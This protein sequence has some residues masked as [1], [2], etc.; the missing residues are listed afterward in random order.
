MANQMRTHG[1][2]STWDAIF[3]YLNLNRHKFDEYGNFDPSPDKRDYVPPALATD[4]DSI[5]PS[6]DRI[7]RRRKTNKPRYGGLYRPGEG[8]EDVARE[9]N[10]NEA[11]EFADGIRYDADKCQSN[12]H[13]EER[14]CGDGGYSSGCWERARERYSNCTRF[15]HYN[16]LPIWT[17][18]D[19][20][21]EADQDLDRRQESKAT[22]DL[23]PKPEASPKPEDE[24]DK[25]ER[26]TTDRA[27]ANLLANPFLRAQLAALLGGPGMLRDGSTDRRPFLRK[28]VVLPSDYPKGMDRP[29]T[30]Y[31]PQPYL[32]PALGG[33]M[34]AQAGAGAMGARLLSLTPR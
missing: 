11:K 28:I 22:G 25:S 29:E 19:E 7:L 31:S 26:T 1:A 20:T 13:L 6:I 21:G 23:K 27:I 5:H 15:G 2:S 9:R 4:P 24:P 12:R 14:L 3:D 32:L 17:L 10:T 33:P 8:P 18:Q 16:G 30:A 34:G